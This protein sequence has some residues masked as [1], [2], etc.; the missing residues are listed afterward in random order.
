MPTAPALWASFLVGQSGSALGTSAGQDLAA[1]CGGHSLSEPM[2]LA[3]L[4]LFGLISSE[5]VR[6]PPSGSWRRPRR[7]SL[8][9]VV[10]RLSQRAIG[11][12]DPAIVNYTLNLVPMSRKSCCFS[13][14]SQGFSRGGV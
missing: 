1:V 2:D 13:G 11:R 12:D 7:G 3:S 14:I 9:D 5:H 6:S 10:G 4:S 8:P